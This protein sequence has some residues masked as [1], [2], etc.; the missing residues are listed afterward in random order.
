MSEHESCGLVLEHKT[1][2][3]GLVAD[4]VHI[5]GTIDDGLIPKL[6]NVT[7]NLEKLEKIIDK[8]N[9]NNELRDNK[10]ESKSEARYIKIETDVETRFI[11]TEG[12]SL[13]KFNKIDSD[14]KLRD[15][16]IYGDNWLNRILTG[17]ITKIISIIFV[18]MVVN[19]ILSSGMWTLL[20][21]RYM[22]ETPGQQQTIL[23]QQSI[24][25]SYLGEKYHIHM[26]ADGRT[27]LH[28]G[29]ETMPAW[30]LDPKTGTWTKCPNNRTEE[31]IK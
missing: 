1:I 27:L 22:L 29:D 9:F 15:A 14:N 31:G 7:K 30:I 6:E 20:K 4:V 28:A 16:T 10:T 12:E 26:L 23:K 24:V 21:T 2:L 3:I 25:P 8:N 11:K 18:F 13:I 5:K 19:A 17:G